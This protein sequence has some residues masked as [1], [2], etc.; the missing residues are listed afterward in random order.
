LRP[1]DEDPL[2][3]IE[4]EPA[5]LLEEGIPYVR[6]WASAQRAVNSLK[7]A[8]AEVGGDNYMPHLR[9]DVSIA[10]TGIVELGRVTPQTVELIA[11]AL[12]MIAARR[13]RQSNG[14]VA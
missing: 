1:D 12:R 5:F 10:G 2:N 6:G 14:H 3:L 13:N 4:G 8:L 11:E 9:A 7:E